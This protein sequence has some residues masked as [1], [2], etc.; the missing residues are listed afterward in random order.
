MIFDKENN[1]TLITQE[2]STIIELVK[3]LQVTYPKFENDNVIINLS[4]LNK[5]SLQDIIE[6]LEISNRHRRAKHSFVIVTDQTNLDEMP[7]EIMVVPTLK[8]AYDVIEMEEMERD[9]G[10]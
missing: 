6:F 7:D 1:T 9:L 10:I 3:K 2:K 4:V 5:V 8:E